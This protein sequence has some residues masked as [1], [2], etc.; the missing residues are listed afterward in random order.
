MKMFPTLNFFVE[1]TILELKFFF[2]ASVVS[3]S[4]AVTQVS[5]SWLELTQTQ[6]HTKL[7]HWQGFG[8]EAVI[9]FILVLTIFACIDN[10]RKDLGGSF[11]LSIGLSITACSLFGVRNQQN[12]LIYLIK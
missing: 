1:V 8:I 3:N 9:T 6:L 7:S 2:K 11:P 10:E 12:I 4:S 5:L